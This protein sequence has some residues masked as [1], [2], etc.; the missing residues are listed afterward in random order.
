M[1]AGHADHDVTAA[2]ATASPAAGNNNHAESVPAPTVHAAAA[3]DAANAAYGPCC[4]YTN[5]ADARIDV[6]ATGGD[7]TPGAMEDPDRAM[8]TSPAAG[9]GQ[10]RDAAES[11]PS[12]PFLH[13]EPSITYV[14]L[15]AET[16]S[17]EQGDAIFSHWRRERQFSMAFHGP[18]LWR[19]ARPGPDDAIPTMPGPARLVLECS[20]GQLAELLLRDHLRCTG[21]DEL[22]AHWTLHGNLRT[23]VIFDVFFLW[24]ANVP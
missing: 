22:G 12:P 9:A 10:G 2:D 21:R 18:L 6:R 23:D 19:L 11:V 16:V 15:V 8:S 4:S 17:H 14:Y 13:V 7:T 1:A 3:D 5:A 20:T 24:N